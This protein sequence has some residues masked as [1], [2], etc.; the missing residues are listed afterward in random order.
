[1]QSVTLQE[2]EYELV[3]R[4]Q[5][6]DREAFCELVR[7]FRTGVINVIYRM[8][9]NA[10]LAEDAAQQTFLSAWKSLTSFQP[11]ASFRSW[12]YRIAVN[13]TLDLLRH[14]KPAVD[15]DLLPLAAPGTDPERRVELRER[16][17]LVR[18]AVLSLPEASRS[19]LVLR[20]YE[21]LS[22]GEIATALEIPVG[23]VMSRLN[24]ARKNLMERLKSELEV[25]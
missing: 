22:Y 18:Q 2:S 12:L 23:T 3:R 16:A 8:C 14:E 5:A 24:Y 20:E 15:I 10:D 9:G 1:M 4:A 17:S 21:G 7:R 25:G 11:R 6:G 13:A 19:V